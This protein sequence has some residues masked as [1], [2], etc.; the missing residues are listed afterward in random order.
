MKTYNINQHMIDYVNENMNT[1][2]D[3]F[4]TGEWNPDTFDWLTE[5]FKLPWLY[6][7]YFTEWF[8]LDRFVYDRTSSMYLAINC[9]EHIEEWWSPD[10]FPEECFE[11]LLDYCTECEDVWLKDYV[12]YELGKA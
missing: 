11:D 2:P 6:P 12:K 8:D 4:A 3:I 5:S 10:R 9:A 7:Q 1:P